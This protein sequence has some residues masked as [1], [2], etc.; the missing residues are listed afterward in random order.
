MLYGSPQNYARQSEVT[1]VASGALATLADVKSELGL[2]ST[3]LDTTLSRYLDACSAAAQ[4][5]CNRTFAQQSMRDTF[6]SIVDQPLG[7]L[8]GGDRSLQLAAYPVATIASVIED[9]ET[10][11]DGTGFIAEMSSGLLSRLDEYG[12]VAR[13]TG[14]KIIVT[15]DAGA[16]PVP[17]D[18]VDAVIEWVKF[19]YFARSRDPGL[20]SEKIDGIYEASFLWGTGPGGPGDMP[21]AVAAVLDR[22]HIPVMA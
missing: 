3:D 22:Y 19:R 9:G 14:E 12:D 4:T 13:W 20:K 10:L 8:V 7:V 2:A 15:Y 1:A 17:A 18:I 6:R 21:V 5:Y 11:A 16:D